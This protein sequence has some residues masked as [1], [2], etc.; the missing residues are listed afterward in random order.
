M[1]TSLNHKKNCHILDKGLHGIPN[2][3][4]F[5]LD[6]VAGLWNLSS[7]RGVQT[8]EGRSTP[9]VG[10]TDDS[11]GMALAP[12]VDRTTTTTK[13]T[14]T[15]GRNRKTSTCLSTPALTFVVVLNPPPT[16]ASPSSVISLPWWP[17][18]SSFVVAGLKSAAQ[19]SSPPRSSDRSSRSRHATI[20]TFSVRNSKGRDVI[21]VP[22]T[23]IS[24]GGR[25]G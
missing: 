25:W 21:V 11:A 12:K 9:R 15:T 8:S 24:V 10:P 23:L 7:G 22:T 20:H 5:A 18:S 3:A 14:M 17:S 13:A 2:I 19:S 1:R 4:G 16:L 6:S